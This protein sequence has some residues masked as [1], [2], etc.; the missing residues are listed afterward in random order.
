MY[1]ARLK[2]YPDKLR[3]R[4]VPVKESDTDKLMLEGQ[5]VFERELKSLQSDGAP[6]MA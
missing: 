1:E 2:R 4:M 3:S 5:N 6:L